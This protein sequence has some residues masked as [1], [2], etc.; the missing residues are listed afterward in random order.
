MIRRGLGVL[1]LSVALVATGFVVIA[2]ASAADL[3][4]APDCQAHWT[5]TAMPGQ[6]AQ[7]QV[8]R[9]EGVAQVGGNEPWVFVRGYGF[10]P[11]RSVQINYCALVHSLATPPACAL[12]GP[13]QSNPSIVLRVLADGTFS[14]SEQVPLQ[15]PSSGTPII[16]V[17]GGSGTASDFYCDGGALACGVVVTDPFS[18]SPPTN[19]P[20]E[21]NSVMI[22]I[23]F[24]ISGGSCP[25]KQVL[26]PSESEFGIS[27]LI[28]SV[29]RL[30]CQGATPVNLFNTEQSGLS[31]VA[32]LYDS[33]NSNSASAVR[34][35]FTDNPESASQQ[36]FLPAG[37]FVLIPVAMSALVVAFS[38]QFY[39][40]GT[41]FP[42]ATYNLSPN[43]VAGIFSGL[44]NRVTSKSDP[45]ECTT[46]CPF[47]PCPLPNECSLIG[48]A[49]TPDGYFPAQSLHAYPL[50]IQ[51][52]QTE[53]LLKWI[54]TAPKG[55]VPFGSTKA[56][57]TMTPA[58][59]LLSGL[60][61]GG[62][63]LKKCPATENQ[64]PAET[65][66]SAAWSAGVGPLG[67]L[68][69]LS[70]A[71]APIGAGSAA[72]SGFAYMNWA[73]AN[74]LGL[75]SANLLT[76]SN[77][78]VGPN[79][80]SL[81]N[82]FAEMSLNK[83]GTYTLNPAKLK[84]DTAYPMPSII[85]AAV[86]TDAMPD[87]R[88]AQIQSAL[89]AMLEVTGGG[90][91]DQLP[92]GY[93]PLPDSL[94]TQ[95]LAEVQHAVGNPNFD[96]GSVLPALATASNPSVQTSITTPG[97]T[98]TSS[99]KGPAK[100]SSPGSVGRGPIPS[101]SPTYGELVAQASGARLMI[102]WIVAVGALA[103]LLSV[104]LLFGTSMASLARRVRA[105]SG[106]HLDSPDDGD[107]E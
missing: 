28:P 55:T 8:G 11:G 18:A 64:W 42:Q 87:T 5:C 76:P 95:A 44:Y 86:S 66:S 24:N 17:I 56:E 37:H 91:T 75:N 92:A 13:F 39:G 33:V 48:L 47:P 29:S 21:A 102:P 58:E 27:P 61:T 35:A 93:V 80:D 100:S 57:E 107:L 78:F 51:S 72:T 68:K 83:D 89:T 94:Y 4:T 1:L 30:N 31:A 36:Q 34:I 88:K 63:P 40:G 54:C 10:T 60:E 62:H 79:K 32:D 74:Y 45:Y 20:S 73:W 97:S 50:S 77:T 43:M 82:A 2:T 90:H 52:G 67:Q 38:A 3:V 23:N 85:Y 41:S 81:T 69:S 46:T 7:V 71:Q 101:S 59:T 99:A 104:P 70:G 49:S 14:V 103:L 26:V 106:A 53:Q 84:S 19:T 6:A 9:T 12:G 15:F 96:I 16:G 105:R 22:P 25:E 98:R 65:I